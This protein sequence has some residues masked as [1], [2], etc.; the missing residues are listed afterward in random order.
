MLIRELHGNSAVELPWLLQFHLG[1]G[2][3][4]FHFYSGSGGN[5]ESYLKINIGGKMR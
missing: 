1:N 3:T 4:G 2:E 5:R